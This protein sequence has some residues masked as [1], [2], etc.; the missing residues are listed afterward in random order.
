MGAF[1]AL[2]SKE[3]ANGARLLLILPLTLPY[4]TPTRPTRPTGPGR[5]YNYYN[6]NYYYY[7]Y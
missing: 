1:G 5:Y 2:F 4:L 7:Y 6:Y 3:D